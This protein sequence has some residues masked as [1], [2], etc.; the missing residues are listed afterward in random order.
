MTA[1]SPSVRGLLW[2]E[3]R[4]TMPLVWMVIGVV[5]LLFLLYQMSG[6]SSPTRS[7]QGILILGLP[8]LFAVGA[9]PLLVSQE[10]E[11]RTMDWSAS[12]PILVNQLF[13]TKFAV[14]LIGLM[15]MWLLTIIMVL[16]TGEP[17]QQI[18]PDWLPGTPVVNFSFW[19]AHTVYLLASGMFAAWRCRTAFAALLLLLPL[20]VLPFMAA[21]IGTWLWQQ[22]GFGYGSP[23]RVLMTTFAITIPMIPAMVVL[24]L[25]SAHQHFAPSKSASELGTEAS[26]TPVA[27]SLASPSDMPSPKPLDATLALVWQSIHD[28]PRLL[29]ILGSGAVAAA[30]ALPLQIVFELFSSQD[31]MLFI[32]A[33]LGTISASWLGVMAF[34]GDGSSLRMKFLADRGVSPG[35]AW[36]SRHVIGVS[37]GCTALLVF[38][39][40]QLAT[41]QWMA[42]QEGYYYGDAM[43]SLAFLCLVTATVYAVSQWTSHVARILAASAFLSLLLSIVSVIYLATAFSNMRLPMGI[44]LFCMS[45]PM[46]AT[47]WTMRTHMEGTRR[48][49][50]W[51]AHATAIVAF[52]LTPFAWAKWSVRNFPAMPAN[53]KET[54]LTEAA[55][56]AFM[57]SP[58]SNLMLV[59]RATRELTNEFGP[60]QKVDQKLKIMQSLSDAPESWIQMPGKDDTGLFADAAIVWQAI[61][62]TELHRLNY[63]ESPS[64]EAETMLSQWMDCL[65]QMTRR[66]RISTRWID[67]EYADQ[68]EVYLAR[69][70]AREGMSEYAE[71]KSGKAVLAMLSDFQGRQDARRRAVLVSWWKY[72]QHRRSSHGRPELGG[73]D[74][75][76][77]FEWVPM[78]QRAWVHDD[79][80]DAFVALA[81]Q[82]IS[83]GQ[84]GESTLRTRQKM[85]SLLNGAEHSFSTSPYSDRLQ[86]GLDPNQVSP[87][88]HRYLVP[89]QRWFAPW[90][91]Q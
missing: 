84:Q 77:W 61:A 12:L 76:E 26:S 29:W 42:H 46:I 36:F 17:F 40:V 44:V 71:S 30:I 28:Q 90:E 59:E 65:T 69:R 13:T 35:R 58:A 73:I 57:P 6:Q 2:K 47:G 39:A 54:L 49:P 37:I 25:R 70:L 91:K 55:Q 4:Q 7:L 22:L 83:Q 79:G 68:I 32:I 48:W 81:L 53:Q 66:L 3:Y 9:G 64:S 43:P 20:A 50:F 51:V 10:K 86:P 63:M 62:T 23:Q 21:S 85:D 60:I 45:V 74:T 11:S 56:L 38:A 75:T 27:D 72:T 88:I 5:G 34:A 19:F 87:M 67:Q 8:A 18:S 52:I 16:S 82:L 41:A 80:V 24:G 1:M 14:A 15:V 33:L 89:C 31:S 78:T